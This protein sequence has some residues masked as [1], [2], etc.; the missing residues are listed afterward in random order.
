VLLILL[1]FS[2]S[3]QLLKTTAV[4]KFLANS[5]A[6][7]VAAILDILLGGCSWSFSCLLT[8]LLPAPL[9]EKAFLHAQYLVHL[10]P[11]CFPPAK[12]PAGTVKTITDAVE[13][14]VMP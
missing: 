14:K 10:A 6:D 11:Y 5:L 7:S 12:F 8:L 4:S 9:H 2:K 3:R 1:I 13:K